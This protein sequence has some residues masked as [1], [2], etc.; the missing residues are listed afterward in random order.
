MPISTCSERVLAV[1]TACRAA[2]TFPT[3][4][5]MASAG[6]RLAT[7]RSS[8]SSPLVSPPIDVHKE[9]DLP[10]LRKGSGL[11]WLHTVTGADRLGADT[12]P[13]LDTGA[14]EHGT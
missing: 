7:R 1:D 11:L 4:S 3:A 6:C 14:G 10:A 9:Q 12:P 2:W 5:W 8:C 13:L